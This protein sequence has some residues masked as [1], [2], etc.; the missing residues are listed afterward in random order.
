MYMFSSQ[1]DVMYMYMHN[2]IDFAF[3]ETPTQRR[4]KVFPKLLHQLIDIIAREFIRGD[5]LGQARV[6]VEAL[7]Q[8]VG[9]S[10]RH[11][12][13]HQRQQRRHDASSETHVPPTTDERRQ[14]Y[15]LRHG[16]DIRAHESSLRVGIVCRMQATP[17]MY[18]MR[19]WSVRTG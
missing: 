15:K 19:T 2:D 4:L 3:D 11:A 1:F 8:Q 18:G 7:L 6:V 9:V 12:Q 13:R 17:R 16:L 14:R 5:W 10:P